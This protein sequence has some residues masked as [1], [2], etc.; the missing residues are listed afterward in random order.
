MCIKEQAYEMDRRLD[1]AI[2]ESTEEDSD[3]ELRSKQSFDVPPLDIGQ[4]DES[5]VSDNTPKT[6]ER[7]QRNV[8]KLENEVQTL[9]SSLRSQKFHKEFTV[10]IT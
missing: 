6:C 5:D 8:D 4:S 1:R 10:D 2:H 7:L 9:L 3:Q